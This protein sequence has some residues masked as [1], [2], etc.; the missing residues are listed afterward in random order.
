MED[1][2]IG[3]RHRPGMCYLPAAS[4]DAAALEASLIENVA[5]CDPDEMTR[6]ETYSLLVEEGR[7][8]NAIA[9]TFGVIRLLMPLRAH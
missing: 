7:T 5:R 8:Q 6:Y 2:S 1:I 9:E 3:S 4:D